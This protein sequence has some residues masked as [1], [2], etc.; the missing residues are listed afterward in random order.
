MIRFEEMGFT[1]GPMDDNMKDSGKE[2]NSTET[3]FIKLQMDPS[4]MV[5]GEM[6][7]D[8]VL[9]DR[10]KQ[11]EKYMKVDLKRERIMDQDSLWIQM[12]K[13]SHMVF[14]IKVT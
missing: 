2:T 14:G 7:S 13:L 8:M 6:E 3:V 1:H 12:G 4:M 10:L 5:P 11:T 9:A